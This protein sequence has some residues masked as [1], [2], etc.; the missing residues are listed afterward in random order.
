MET[1]QIRVL[2]KGAQRHVFETNVVSRS[3]IVVLAQNF[4]FLHLKIEKKNQIFRF[5]YSETPN[6][7]WEIL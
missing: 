2:F 5:F 6:L 7:R 4:A 1:L 3:D